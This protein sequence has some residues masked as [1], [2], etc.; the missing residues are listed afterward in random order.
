M[1][2]VI[3]RSGLHRLIQESPR[4][5]V[6]SP[7][8]LR[9][10]WPVALRMWA[11]D[12]WERKQTLLAGQLFLPSTCVSHLWWIMIIHRVMSRK[13]S[14][15]IPKKMMGQ[16]TLVKT[17]TPMIPHC[18]VTQWNYVFFLCFDPNISLWL[19]LHIV[20]FSLSQHWTSSIAKNDHMINTIWCK[21]CLSGEVLS[22]CVHLIS[23]L[24]HTLDTSNW[25]LL[26]KII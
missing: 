19:K 17:P 9:H 11:N 23:I 12:V 18:F 14:V 13:L 26:H 20:P 6:L 4:D 24:Y 25:M 8:N 21:F 3:F 7:F 1:H 16:E 22:Y 10:I 15:Q 2:Y 5:N